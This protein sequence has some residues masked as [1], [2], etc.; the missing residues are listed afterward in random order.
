[1]TAVRIEPTER[2]MNTEFAKL[3]EESAKQVKLKEGEIITGKV[4]RITRD[5]VVVDIGFKSEGQ[6]SIDEFKN[7]K[8]EVSTEPG[9]EISVLLESVE[10]EH[11]MMMLSKERADAMRTWD[12]LVEV[13]DNNGEIEGMVVSKVKGGLS[14]DIGVKAFLP[15]SQVDLRPVRNLDKYVGNSYQFKIIKLNKRRGNVVLSRKAILEKERETMREATIANL[16]EGQVFDGI[17]KNVTEYGVFVDL[18]GIDGL[19]HVTDMTWGRIN[20]PSEMFSVGDDIRV[21][22]L[23]FDQES[24]KVS[25]GLKQLQ[26][27]PWQNVEDHYPVGS[28]VTGKVVSLT[29]Y[30]AFISLED[31]VE[32][33][34][35][36]SEMSW[37]KK[38]KH[39]SKVLSVGDT[40]DAIILDVDL[41]AKR[42]SLGLK[43]IEA[44]PWEQLEDKFPLGTKLKGTVRNIADFGIF[45]DVAG[46]VDGL[47]HI[48]DMAWVQNFAHPSEIFNKG[49]EVEVIVLHIDPENE[50][51]SL[52]I[53]QLLDDP[54]DKI[55]GTYGEGEKS[56]GKVTGLSGAGAV[57]EIAEGVEGLIPEKQFPESLKAGDE[58]NVIVRQADPRERKFLLSLEGAEETPTENTEAS[59]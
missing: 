8:G 15:G 46:E 55:N 33:L 59:E 32:G 34:I 26:P 11:G 37:T 56:Q 14:V 20:H 35:H 2:Q 41:D 18:G 31:G 27:D 9:D 1:M 30:G 53:K 44:N 17:V 29:D 36:I 3:F 40:V 24:G 49:D 22:V 54:W 23:K 10:N 51:F 5:Y 7:M 19:L 13:S 43:Q 45:I 25:L 50:R 48:S 21:V 6:I 4:V 12:H 38:V 16:A 58:V 52:G 39:P 47:V 57:V 28:R 42:I